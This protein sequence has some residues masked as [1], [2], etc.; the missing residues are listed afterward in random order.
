MY[1][2]ADVPEILVDTAGVSA[3]PGSGPMISSPLYATPP[4]RG[5]RGVSFNERFKPSEGATVES[6]YSLAHSVETEVQRQLSGEQEVPA[7][8]PLSEALASKGMS[9]GTRTAS[10]SSASGGDANTSSSSDSPSFLS[11][12]HEPTVV[13]GH[14]LYSPIPKKTNG[15]GGVTK[16]VPKPRS[17]TLNP[18]SLRTEQLGSSHQQ[19]TSLLR[20][21]D[22][23]TAGGTSIRGGGRAEL[24]D[25]GY[26]KPRQASR[27]ANYDHLPPGPP[28]PGVQQIPGSHSPKQ[29]RSALLRDQN[30]SY[31]STPTPTTSEGPTPTYI[32]VQH[33]A[34]EHLPPMVD[35]SKKP[36]IPSPPRIDRNLKP[37]NS[38]EN[39]GDSSESPIFPTR[40]TSLFNESKSH[41]SQPSSA[42]ADSPPELP[43][44]TSSLAT[45]LE[46]AAL[47]SEEG[48]F[49]E[50]DLPKPSTRTMQ[51]TQVEFDV[52]TGNPAIAEI[53]NPPAQ[54]NP[55][56]RQS[57]LSEVRR[58]PIPAPRTGIGRVNYSDVD[59]AATSALAKGIQRNQVTLREAER[60]ALKDKPYVN[61]S[62]EGDVDD[63]SNPDYYVHMRVSD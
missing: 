63:E 3:S 1:F 61:V 48:G 55:K 15:G 38:S 17:A 16:P 13:D 27:T 42:S 59:I 53:D 49:S 6:M 5:G 12:H 43:V 20:V 47:F 30:S 58:N 34:E 31:T 46:A 14:N 7:G 45:T 21:S 52:K 51:Y 24:M 54:P 28:R 37:K 33:M 10:I 4:A 60:Q 29:H 22:S 50:R 41:D 9:S 18:L 32:N 25:N 39:H 26:M 57:S 36:S 56:K 35:R 23:L 40:T 19:F 62:R 8:T 2:T 44:R 11:P